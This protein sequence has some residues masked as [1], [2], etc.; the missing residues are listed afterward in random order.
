LD[1]IIYSIFFFPILEAWRIFQ[2]TYGPRLSTGGEIISYFQPLSNLFNLK[3][4]SIVLPFFYNTMVNLWG[5]IY[6]VTLLSF[7]YFI[8]LKKWKDYFLIFLIT[9]ILFAMLLFGTFVN[10]YLQESGCFLACGDAATRLSMF[11]YPLLVFCSAL[12]FGKY[13]D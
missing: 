9:F 5:P 11:I 7:V 3:Q 1:I 2:S 4:W 10:S 13:R 6:I 8:V 12:A